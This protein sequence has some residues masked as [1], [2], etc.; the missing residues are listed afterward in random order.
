MTAITTDSPVVRWEVWVQQEGQQQIRLILEP[1]T[2]I[3]DDVMQMVF[4]NIRDEYHAFT[5]V[6]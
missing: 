4:G 5:N 1:N 2:E 3:I 6:N